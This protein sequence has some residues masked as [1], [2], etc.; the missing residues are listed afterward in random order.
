MS[1]KHVRTI[2]DLVRFGCGLRI[3]CGSCGSAKTVDGYDAA[4]LGGG[5]ELG[6]LRRKLKCARCGKKDASLAV[7]PPV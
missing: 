1:T 3:E 6:A 5:Q 2:A 7:L 4:K